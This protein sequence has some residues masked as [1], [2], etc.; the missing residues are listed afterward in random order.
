M[1]NKDSRREIRRLLWRWGR[2]TA[3]C[4]HKQREMREYMDLIDSVSDVHAG[5]LTGMPGSGKISDNTARAAE[6][7]IY[8]KQQYKIQIDMLAK[9]IE[10]ELRFRESIDDLMRSVEDPARTVIEMRY[11][12]CWSFTRI[13]QE[14]NYAESWVKKLEGI[15][16]SIIGKNITIR[17]EDTKRYL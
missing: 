1:E 2:V 13:S 16:I 14:L 10:D 3:T 12:Y 17:K 7:L 5:V 11:K 6:K 8:L 9:E 15:A 4:I